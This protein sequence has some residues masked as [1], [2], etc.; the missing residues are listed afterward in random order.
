MNAVAVMPSQ[1][2]IRPAGLIRVAMPRLNKC[3]W[4]EEYLKQIPSRD[5]DVQWAEVTETVVL[6]VADWNAFMRGELERER[7]QAQVADDRA[8]RAAYVEARGQ[9]TVIDR[10]EAG[11]MIRAALK[12]AFPLTRFE[13]RGKS[14]SGGQSI[15]VSW[16]DGPTGKQVDSIIDR[17]ESKGFDGMTDCGYNRGDRVLCGRSVSFNTGY[18]HGS[19][20]ESVEL[21]RRVIGLLGAQCGIVPEVNEYGGVV[22]N[23]RVPFAW[24]EFWAD[25]TLTLEQVEAGVL[26][27][28]DEGSWFSDIVNRVLGS[29]S[30]E[31]T[32]TVPPELLPEYPN[33]TA[34]VGTGRAPGEARQ[35]MHPGIVEDVVIAQVIQ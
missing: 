32:G 29:L 24:H 21:R 35:L 23:L 18:V 30:L 7:I 11:K 31:D 14:Y 16:T 20:H 2:V 4:I 17:Y 12:R 1:N 25:G 26:A 33:K 28:S 27:R 19:R 15:D 5:Y 22:S 13:V 3:D 9:V 8:K 6:S 10:V 34:T